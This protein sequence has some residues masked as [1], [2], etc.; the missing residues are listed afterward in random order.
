MSGCDDCWD[1]VGMME[2]LWTYY[3]QMLKMPGH[4]HFKSLETLRRNRWITLS[5][6]NKSLSPLETGSNVGFCATFTRNFTK[7]TPGKTLPSPAP[8]PFFLRHGPCHRRQGRVGHVAI[9]IEIAV[10]QVQGIG[11]GKAATG[12]CRVDWHGLKTTQCF[13]NG[14]ACH[15]LFVEWCGVDEN[16]GRNWS[17]NSQ[18]S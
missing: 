18:H 3:R 8:P 2:L 14:A 7:S 5:S 4:M 17:L 12:Q 10:R 13:T 15:N 1:L 16:A 11:P 9:G 6:A